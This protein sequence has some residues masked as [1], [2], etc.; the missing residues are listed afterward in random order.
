MGASVVNADTTGRNMQSCGLNGDLQDRIA[1]C[2]NKNG[3]DAIRAQDWVLVMRDESDGEFVEAWMIK[4]TDQLWLSPEKGT[5][6]FD[7][8]KKQCHSRGFWLASRQ[9]FEKAEDAGMRE[10][11]FFLK[12]KLWWT[13]TH[14]DFPGAAF[15][16]NGTRGYTDDGNKTVP[17]SV[18]CTIKILN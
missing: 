4:G 13:Y 8:A 9:E 12:G 6:T 14:S 1:D 16:Y 7:E 17:H 11:L 18:V 5:F 10:A 2:Q 3:K 15:F